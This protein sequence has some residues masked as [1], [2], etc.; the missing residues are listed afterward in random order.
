[1]SNEVSTPQEVDLA[2]KVEELKKELDENRK[3]ADAK[4]TEI[5]QA[6]ATL[7]KRLNEISNI[8][9]EQQ[10]KVQ[11]KEYQARISDILEKAKVDPQSAGILLQQMLDEKE[12]NMMQKIAPKINKAVQNIVHVER[13]KDKYPEFIPHEELIYA[14]V[15]LLMERDA[16]REFTSTLDE[17]VEEIKKIKGNQSTVT[18]EQ[19]AP[20][21][22]GRGEG[23]PNVSPPAS[24]KKPEPTAVFVEGAE[25]I[26]EENLRIAREAVEERNALLR[27]R[28]SVGIP[29]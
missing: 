5:S 14:K 13:L 25:A 26:R 1:M 4:I 23:S 24:P 22:A 20:S 6:K 21:G 7:E 15:K 29:K 18:R 2:K 11:I 10:K 3:Q 12:S 17:V 8:E 16:N 27:K 19:P 9:G 28:A